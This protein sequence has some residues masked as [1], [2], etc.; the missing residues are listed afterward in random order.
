MKTT[1]ELGA[2]VVLTAQHDS[3]LCP[4]AALKNHLAINAFI[5]GTS[6]LFAYMTSS[7]QPKNML[8]HEFLIRKR[9]PSSGCL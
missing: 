5:P 6:A 3:P 2:S 9:P 7:G 4:V 1:K 8:K